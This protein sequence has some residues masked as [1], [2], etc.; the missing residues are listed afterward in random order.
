MVAVTVTVVAGIV[1]TTAVIGMLIRGGFMRYLRGM[2]AVTI[3][4]GN[5]VADGAGV[6][7]I[8]VVCDITVV[9]DIQVSTLDGPGRIA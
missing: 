8:V 1:T 5:A 3:G 7:T 2:A 9:G 4:Q 6:A